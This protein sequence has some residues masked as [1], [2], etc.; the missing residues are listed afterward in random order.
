MAFEGGGYKYDAVI[1]FSSCYLSIRL[2]GLRT[3]LTFVALGTPRHHYGLDESN[4]SVW[5]PA[6]ETPRLV[7]LIQ[8][9]L[10][11]TIIAVL[12]HGAGQADTKKWHIVG[13]LAHGPPLMAAFSF[14]EFI[15]SIEMPRLS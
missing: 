9:Y 1:F 2:L 12:R 7:R 15:A 14:I 10:L 5:L 6:A 13:A 3:V 4:R 11:M 8:A